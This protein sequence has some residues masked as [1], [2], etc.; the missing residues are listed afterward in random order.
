M[1]LGKYPFEPYGYQ[2][3]FFARKQPATNLAQGGGQLFGLVIGSIFILTIGV[4]AHF[5]KFTVS[6]FQRAGKNFFY[7]LCDALSVS[8]D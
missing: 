6:L 3:G 4:L 2:G 8:K 7:G 5:V 1:T